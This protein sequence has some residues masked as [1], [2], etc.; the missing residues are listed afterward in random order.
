VDGA[1]VVEQVVQLGRRADMAVSRSTAQ[2][3]LSLH[4]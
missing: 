1:G 4:Y 2:Q 3:N